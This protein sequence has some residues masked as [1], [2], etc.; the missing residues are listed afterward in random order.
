[1]RNGIA[2]WFLFG[3]AIVATPAQAGEVALTGD[4]HTALTGTKVGKKLGASKYLDIQPS[5]RGYL[6]FDLS[7][8]PPGTVESQIHHAAL[9][10]YIEKLKTPGSLDVRA[11]GS[12]WNEATVAGITDPGFLVGTADAVGVAADLA[13]AKSFVVVDVTALVKAWVSGALPNH[14]FAVVSNAGTPINARVSSREGKEPANRPRLEISFGIGGVEGPEGPQ[15][16]QGIQGPQGLKGDKGDTG[17]QGPIGVTGPTGA[18]GPAGPQ[19]LK[20]D[21]GDK[22][23]PGATGATGPQG[24]KGDKGDTGAQGP[25]GQTGATGA[26]GPQGIPGPQGPQGPAGADSVV[27]AGTIESAQAFTISATEA[28]KGQ[29]VDLTVT[30]SQKVFVCATICM[31]S[32]AAAGAQNLSLRLRHQQ[33][34][35]AL[36]G[37]TTSALSGLRVAANTKHAFTVSGVLD[38]PAAGTYKVGVSAYSATD[39]ASWN[40]NS[41]VH[42]TYMVLN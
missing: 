10:L 26:T 35:G 7:S 41:F 2:N 37:G 30:A 32:T 5:T 16:P 11:A 33:G 34:S 14:G 21:K 39:A 23:D 28:F 38:F 22:G 40:N 6:K 15:G 13:D 42:M 3:V 9:W 24:V 8:L 4:V 1:M 20:G 12:V 29:T 17:S 18:P 36:T 27:S 31:G 19:G 25:I